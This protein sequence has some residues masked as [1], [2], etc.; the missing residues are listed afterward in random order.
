MQKP[1]TPLQSKKSQQCCMLC[2]NFRL[3]ILISTEGGCTVWQAEAICL[4]KPSATQAYDLL[5]GMQDDHFVHKAGLKGF[6]G[7]VVV[8]YNV[9][10]RQV[11]PIATI[12]HLDN[13]ENGC[14]QNSPP[15]PG[16]NHCTIPFADILVD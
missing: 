16:S 15:I 6:R 1:H 14:S 8:P 7:T 13:S 5:R 4:A 3:R 11:L 2:S 9:A 10:R 12:T